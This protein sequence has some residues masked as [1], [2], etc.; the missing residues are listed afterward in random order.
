MFKCEELDKD[1]DEL[2][3]ADKNNFWLIQRLTTN[4]K[5]ERIQT[6]N[7]STCKSNNGQNNLFEEFCIKG[8]KD[9]TTQTKDT[10]LFAHF[11]E[12]CI[13]EL[14]INEEN[15]YK[16]IGECDSNCVNEGCYKDGSF[17]EARLD[18]PHSMAVGPTNDVLY[19][20]DKNEV[21]VANITSE[22]VSLLVAAE[23][24]RPYSIAALQN[25]LMVVMSTGGP[26][27]INL[28]SDNRTPK[29]LDYVGKISSSYRDMLLLL[30][31]NKTYLALIDKESLIP[32]R[33]IFPRTI[34]SHPVTLGM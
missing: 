15:I 24:N 33:F 26:L 30:C 27:E 14:I 7:E 11:S 16:Y 9:F 6:K 22:K 10:V 29:S 2:L 8:I 21:R 25:Y 18:T 13:R 20:T 1:S 31:A 28:L 32:F 4:T 34:S 23:T 3:C 17:T 19:I 5:V 12:N